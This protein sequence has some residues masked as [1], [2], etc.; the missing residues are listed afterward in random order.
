MTM[1]LGLL[2]ALSGTLQA[3]TQQAYKVFGSS[4][5]LEELMKK[6]QDKFYEIEK[7]RHE[8]VENSA[9]EAYLRGYWERE[10]KKANKSP[11]QA[12]TEYMKTHVKVADA[13]V[14]EMLEKYKDHPNLKDLPAAEKQTQIK[15]F[16]QQKGE[17]AVIQNIIAEGIKKK[18]L[19]VLVAAPKEPVFSIQLT[20][21]DHFRYGPSEKDVTPVKGGCSG[22]DCKITVVEYSEYQCPFCSRVLA[23]NKQVLEKYKGKIRWVVRDFPLSFHD[24]ARPAAIAAKCAAEQGKFWD[25]YYTLFDN[26]Q[27]LAPSDL[28]S[29]ATKIKLDSKQYAACVANPQKVEKIIDENL[30]SGLAMGVSGTPAFF[31]GVKEANGKIT[32]RRMSGALPFEEMSRVIEEELKKNS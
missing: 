9:K 1:K 18:D 16:L 24:K 17:S 21:N 22:D 20:A 27:K 15:N 31:I 10:G 14:K 5:S 6:E 30:N 32:A 29:Y 28:T 7:A 23:T 4:V 3:E 26:Q 11:E 8:L 12:K 25:M 2:C 13:E 19:E